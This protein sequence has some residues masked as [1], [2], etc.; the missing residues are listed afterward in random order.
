MLNNEDKVTLTP[1]FRVE[2]SLSEGIKY[3]LQSSQTQI[4]AVDNFKTL[5]FY[6]FIDKQK[7]EE[8]EKQKAA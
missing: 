6:E 1:H 7:K 5:K 8:E 2:T 4:V 3:L